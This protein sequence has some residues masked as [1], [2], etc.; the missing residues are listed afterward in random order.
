M[1]LNV[2]CCNGTDWCLG[3]DFTTC[4]TADERADIFDAVFGAGVKA[5]VNVQQYQWGQSHLT[6]LPH[7]PIRRQD[8]EE[9][10]TIGTSPDDGYAE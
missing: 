2:C 3:K 4:T 6:H 5:G 8:S 7:G 1:Q 10:N 9:Q